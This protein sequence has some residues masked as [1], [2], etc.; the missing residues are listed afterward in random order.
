MAHHALLICIFILLLSFG[1]CNPVLHWFTRAQTTCPWQW[2]WEDPITRTDEIAWTVASTAHCSITTCTGFMTSDIPETKKTP[3]T[4]HDEWFLVLAEV[5]TI[6]EL[7]VP[8]QTQDAGETT[9]TKATEPEETEALRTTSAVKGINSED[10]KRQTEGVCM[11]KD[12]ENRLVNS[13]EAKSAC[14]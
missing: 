7:T 12:K 5:W 4:I 8:A 3:Y 11:E 6:V 9:K 10:I 14:E 13:V 1:R 2:W